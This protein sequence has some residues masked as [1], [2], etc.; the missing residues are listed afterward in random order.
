MLRL[1]TE[2]R[3]WLRTSLEQYAPI[4]DPR[5]AEPLMVAADRLFEAGEL[6][7]STALRLLIRRTLARNRIYLP[8]P[9]P[10]H[11]GLE[12]HPLLGVSL[13]DDEFLKPARRLALLFDDPSM[14][15]SVRIVLTRPIEP[16]PLESADHLH[17][18]ESMVI[19]GRPPDV[20]DLLSRATSL[21]GLR[22]LTIKPTS[23]RDESGNDVG[24]ISQLG[25]ARH[26]S[27]LEYLNATRYRL[28]GHVVSRWAHAQRFGTLKVLV[29]RT[30]PI[31]WAGLRAIREAS[32]FP[33][34]RRLDLLGSGIGS[35]GLIELAASS[36]F[37]SLE[38][39][40]LIGN[41][42]DDRGASALLERLDWPNLRRLDLDGNPIG[43]QMR[44]LLVTAPHLRGRICL[45]SDNVPDD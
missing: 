8:Q 12:M 13:D 31:G 32:A 27:N 43:D 39:V 29:L 6:F 41:E 10:R 21:D 23:H 1:D 19:A 2:F 40:N 3:A 25:Q 9:N 42:I 4:R 30:N 15:S 22:S 14:R 37:R 36:H 17:S 7:A 35:D 24:A 26:L 38:S 18:I 5:S 20:A 16:T 44:R 33:A 28:D 11:L 34:L 45:A